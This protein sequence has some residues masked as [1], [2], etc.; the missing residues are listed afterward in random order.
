M[1]VLLVWFYGFVNREGTTD[2]DESFK[3]SCML[4]D[5]Y[6]GWPVISDVRWGGPE[7]IDI[8]IVLEPIHGYISMFLFEV[9]VISFIILDKQ[10]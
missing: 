3:N 10:I 2:S 8:A 6:I 1:N 9:D 7:H 5:G 4:D